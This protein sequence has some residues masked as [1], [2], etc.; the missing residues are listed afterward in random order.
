MQLIKWEPLKEINRFFN[1]DVENNSPTLLSFSKLGFDLAVDIYE[2][3]GQ[4]VAK[5]SLPGINP[6]ELDISIEN[7]IL[8]ISGRRD[9]EKETDKKDYYHKEIRR[10]S[11]LRT[12]SLPKVVDAEKAEATYDKGEL[13][14]YMPII[15]ESHDKGTKVK[16]KDRS[17]IS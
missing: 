1:E 3:N 2:E 16:I 12:V 4:L 5:M 7:E 9:E 14:I 17:L 8:S 15:A 10:G 13:S 11:F 6:Q